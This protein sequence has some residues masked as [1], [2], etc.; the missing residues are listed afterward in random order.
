MGRVSR[1]G[2]LTLAGAGVV[3]PGCADAPVPDAP[4][5]VSHA[6]GATQAGASDAAAALAAALESAWRARD[7]RA[8]VAALASGTVRA[9]AVWGSWLALSADV[10]AEGA[11]LSVRW[12]AAGESRDTVDRVAVRERGVLEPPV[13]PRPVWFDHPVEV[14]TRGGATVLGAS[15]TDR[16][17]LEAWA[18]AASGAVGRL[19][20]AALSPWLE[21]WEGTL[22]V[23]LPADALHLARLTGVWQGL[24]ATAAITVQHAS[25]V[26]PRVVLNPAA[27]ALGVA[28]RTSLLVH[29]G[30]HA[31]TGSAARWDAPRWLAEGLA[32]S[33][34]CAADADRA[35][36]NLA[37]ARGG[38]GVPVIDPASAPDA[39]AYARAQLAYDACV[40]AWGR[41]SV[42]GWASGRDVAP[43]PGD[44]EIEQ[45]YAARLLRLG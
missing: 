10:A 45:A 28:E 4:V 43:P 19:R 26:P 15:G 31:I 8:F 13:G 38:G 30:V 27:S 44:V 29:E 32:E 21:R 11:V 5:P 23:V 18:D 17:G 41:D 36:R 1:R 2:F 33:V 40:D 25:D 42:H 7:E 39:S 20:D 6:P 35:A 14:A 12:R 9:R 16:A 37:L 34:A 22:V 3:V 24:D